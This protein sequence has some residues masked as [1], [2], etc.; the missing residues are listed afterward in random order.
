[1]IWIALLC[2]V[3]MT[4]AAVAV[5]VLR[6]LMAAVIATSVINFTLALVFVILRAPDVAMT[7]AV[8]GAGFSGVL[9]ALTLKKLNLLG[10]TDD[11][12]L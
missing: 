6:N 5:V 4:T 12:N 2:V 7:E 3:V 8:I 10:E 9:L 1:M 11:E